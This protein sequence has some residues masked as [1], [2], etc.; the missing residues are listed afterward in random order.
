MKYFAYGSNMSSRRL[1]YRTPNVECIG[2]YMLKQYDLRF[3]KRSVDGSGKCDAFFTG[4]DDDLTWGVV[5]EIDEEEKLYLDTIEGVGKG[6]EIQNVVVHDEL[7]EKLDVFMYVA[8]DIDPAAIPYSWYKIHVLTGALESYL[9]QAYLEK[10]NA[11]DVI[12][13][14]NKARELQ[15]LA[16]YKR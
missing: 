7:G 11:V 3:H 9:P 16:I 2:V 5:Y 1:K 14:D 4:H 12:A 6:Y 10:I 8:T 13:D 15:E